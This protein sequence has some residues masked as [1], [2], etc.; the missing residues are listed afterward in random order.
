MIVHCLD[1]SISQA[2]TVTS[3]TFSKFKNQP[4]PPSL[5][6]QYT[7]SWNQPLSGCFTLSQC[8]ILSPR[9][10]EGARKQLGKYGMLSQLSQML[11]TPLANPPMLQAMIWLL[12]RDLSFT[13]MT[14]PVASV[15]SM[16]HGNIY[17]TRK[18]GTLK[19]SLLPK[20]R[21]ISR[22]NE[23]CTRPVTSGPGTC[24]I[25][26]TTRSIRLGMEAGERGMG[27]KLDATS[28]G[29]DCMCWTYTL[30]LQEIM[31]HTM[32][33]CKGRVNMQCFMPMGMCGG[34]WVG[35]FQDRLL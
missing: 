21:F 8:V 28:A 1:T 32:Q 19:T 14:R 27:A 16:R 2:K 30:W 12:W 7:A 26:G 23:P 34:W 10:G 22:Q 15:T 35:C 33:M 5:L 4:W 18:P 3:R 31:L 25:S 13:S 24:A 11:S 6:S 20:Q 29:S 9:L 17:F